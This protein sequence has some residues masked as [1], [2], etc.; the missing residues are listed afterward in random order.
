MRSYDREVFD[1]AI[2][3]LRQDCAAQGHGS[4]DY[5]SNGLGTHWTRCLRC[6]GR[7]EH[8][9][10]GNQT[11]DEPCQIRAPQDPTRSHLIDDPYRG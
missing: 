4:V 8:W 1:P 2:A 5:E 9:T 11:R 3:Q 10:E 7:V 6:G